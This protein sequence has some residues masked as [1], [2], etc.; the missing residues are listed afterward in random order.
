MKKINNIKE[1]KAEQ[2][3]IADRQVQIEQQIQNDWHRLK[4]SLQPSH[5]ARQAF[6]HIREKQEEKHEKEQ[7]LKNGFI[8][9]MQ[10]LAEKFAEKA[11]EKVGKYF[12]GK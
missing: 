2:Q 7:I 4:Q 10:L 12:N 9:A 3:R 6:E 8:Y 5:I 1:F 11:S